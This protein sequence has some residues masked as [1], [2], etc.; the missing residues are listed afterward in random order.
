MTDVTNSVEA[1]GGVSY[2]AFRFDSPKLDLT[3]SGIVF[4]SLSQSGR[5]RF[6]GNAKFRFELL[7]D[8]FFNITVFE[9]YDSKPP[10]QTGAKNDFGITTSFGWS[11]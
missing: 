5:V 8:L 3:A 4:P 1:L 6:D 10:T 7:S 11:F 2:E 9:N